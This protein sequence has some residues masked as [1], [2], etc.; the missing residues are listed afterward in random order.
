M[1]PG[2]PIQTQ[3]SSVSKGKENMCLACVDDLLVVVVMFYHEVV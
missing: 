2:F 1:S 3:I